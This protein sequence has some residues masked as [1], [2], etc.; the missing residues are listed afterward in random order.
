M[1]DEQITQRQSG[2]RQILIGNTL[3]ETAYHEAGHIVIAAAVG[4]DLKVKGIVIYEVESVADG[5]VF[6]WEDKPDWENI[7]LALRGGQLAQLR[8]FPDSEFRGAQ[9]DVQNFFSV[10]QQHFPPNSNGDVWQDISAKVKTLLD[11]HWAA[12]EAVADALMHSNWIPVT[13]DEHP[14]AKRKKHLDGAAL[15]AIL[16]AHG[17][18]A[19]VR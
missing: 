17:I 2:M 15:A 12:V 13:P 7:L 11:N 4:L 10:V 6:Y 9:Q 16:A 5:W 18:P 8:K 3:E 14:R 19:H 1:T